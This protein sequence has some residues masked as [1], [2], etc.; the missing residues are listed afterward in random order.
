MKIKHL[1]IIAAGLMMML[2]GC[3]SNNDVPVAA[4][5]QM[6]KLTA[7]IILNT[8]STILLL[9]DYLRFPNQI[10]SLQT[11]PSLIAT[12]STDS[13][14]M[15]IRPI[16]RNFPRLSVLTIWS[17][18]FPY[19]LLMEKTT[20]QHVWFAFN[21]KNKKYKRV[22]IK[23]QMNDWN[24]AA[25]NLFE[26]EGKWYI[27]LH[28]FPGKYQYKMV[29][30]GKEISDPD[31]HDSVTNNMGGYNSLMI[32]GNPNPVKSPILF[33]Q[34]AN[35]RKITVG[36][37]NNADSIYVFWENNLLGN[38]FW[39]KDTAG[40][41]IEVPKK[42]R[43]FNRSFLRVW[44]YNNAGISN[45]ILIPLNDGKVLTDASKLKRSDREAMIMYFLMVDRFKNGNKEN[46]HPVI[47]S[48]IDPRVNY[49]GGD[50]AGITKE[51]ATG[52]F[53]SLGI[54]TLW[55]SPITQNPLEG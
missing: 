20:K 12:I 16:Q 5:P 11:D 30:D 43:E 55:I 22:Q 39:K 21:P 51:I 29:V 19:S 37:K 36:L 46:D 8:D 34:E 15:V 54:N 35:G 23:G 3:G 4:E 10:D 33:T 9:A 31:N 48:D 25:G 6:V 53:S 24:P 52:Y 47:D 18:G 50:L 45:E 26:K 42:A 38:A 32:V 7:P 41:S 27:D 28:V 40:I 14:I 17:K 2:W 1:Q 44:A 49:M 13:T